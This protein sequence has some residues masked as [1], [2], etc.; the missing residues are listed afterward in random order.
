VISYLTDLRHAA[1][2]LL[3]ARAFTAVCVVSLGLG[4]GVVI[5]ILIFMRAVLGTPPRVVE[6]GLAELVVRP[7]GQLQAQAG[8]AIVDTWSY[9]DYLDVREAARG[10]VITGWSRAEELFQPDGAAAVPVA[11]MYAS[12]N[13][14]STI[15][16][17]LPLGRGFK[18]VDDV[19]R[20]EAEAVIS[21][22]WW[23]V[24]FA[25]DPDII[26]RTITVNRTEYVVVGVAPEGF[27]G[28]VAGLNEPY[29]Q[30]WLPL[31]HH[32][33]LTGTDD[34]RLQRDAGWVRIVARLEAGTT[35]A[36]ADA[37]VQAAMA[38]L[39]SRYPATNAEKGGGVE[40]Y[41]PTGARLRSQINF[42]RMMILGLSG[43]VLL[44]V[45]L[46]ISG[47]MLVRSAIRE[48]DLAIR[49]ALGASRWRLMRH[50][51]TEALV[52]ALLGGAFASA[53]VFG[54]PLVVAWALD[55]WGPM[56][57][58]FRPDLWLVL[59]CV[60]LCFVTSLVLG[61]LPAIRFS[62]TSVTDTLKND[63]SG[64]GRRVGRLQRLTA[65]AQAGIAVPF[66]VMCGVQFDQ[67]RVA[68]LTDVGF[69]PQGLYGVRLNLAAIAKTDEERRLFLR[70]ARENLSR[71]PGVAAA[72]VGDGVPLDFIYR[73]ARVALE[74]EGAFMTVHTTRVGP[75]YLDTIGTRLLAGRMIDANDREGAERVVVLSAPLANTLYPSGDPLGKRIT[76]AANGGE[77]QTYTVVGVTADL[78]ST[79]MGNP[80]PQLFLS[81]DQEPAASVLLIARGAPSDPSMRAAFDNA[82]AD[83]L[84]VTSTQQ[85]QGAGPEA[86]LFRELLTGEGLIENSRTDLL[87]SSGVGGAAAAVALVLAALGVYGVIA[88][89]VATRTREIGVRVAL[90]ASPSRVLRDVL[91][92]ALK[93]VVPGIGVGLLLAVAWVRLGDPAWY[94]LGGVEPLVYSVAAGT[95]FLV[96]VLAGI[97]SARRAAAVQPIVAMRA[98]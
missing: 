48:R 43:I 77:T 36:Q 74:G 61:F 83:A 75:G 67:A 8:G 3:R 59:Q 15:G 21:H 86:V 80:R 5:A 93:L 96:A 87:T 98:E 34:A 58:L 69:E 81:L 29:Y 2:T 70:T 65:A 76:V 71:T 49:A 68:A 64:S 4:M 16:V 32:P 97:P 27:R 50:H 63:S 95:A 12:T 62:R 47:M 20:A 39:A 31:S 40:P 78:V 55:T 18:P 51:L 73:N 84:R 88:F 90:G 13:Y 26:G 37:A 6:D 57:D 46:N 30:L 72:S 94:P 82:L 22:R 41:I 33:R 91:G 11:T 19:S 66:L 44:V 17:T 54:G 45:G 85:P 53:V 28:H 25:A 9:P 35:V 60:A 52:V 42:A 89:M 10:M 7:S 24:R 1:R 92:D 79:Q 23:Q 38:A 56:L 14:F